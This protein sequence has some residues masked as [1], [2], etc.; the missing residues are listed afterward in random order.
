LKIQKNA[1]IGFYPFQI[2]INTGFPKENEDGSNC[3]TSCPEGYTLKD[4]YCIKICENFFDEDSERCEESCNKYYYEGEKICRSSPCTLF[5]SEDEEENICVTQCEGN[6]KI[7]KENG[8]NMCVNDCG[9]NYFVEEK[10][11]IRGVQ[12]AIKRCIDITCQEY[13]NEYGIIYFSE[14]GKECLKTCNEA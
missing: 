10:I 3:V 5:K 9:D 6:Q 14:N 7:K 4:N 13:S 11:E 12:R 8:N 2:D 1:K